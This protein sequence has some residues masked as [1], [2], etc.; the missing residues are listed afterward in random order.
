MKFQNDQ[1]QKK[2][3]NKDMNELTQLDWNYLGYNCLTLARQ[4]S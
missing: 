3:S 4:K 1:Q 2:I